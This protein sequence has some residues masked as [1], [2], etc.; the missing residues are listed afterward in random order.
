[1]CNGGYD[2]FIGLICGT[3]TNTCC[4]LPV[5]A[6]PKLGGGGGEMLVNLESGAFSGLPQ[7][8]FDAELDKA[9]AD[10]GAYRLEKMTSGAYLGELCR[11]TLRGAARDGLFSPQA[12]EFIMDL[13]YLS[14][15]D[16]D[17]LA[18]GA[19]KDLLPGAESNQIQAAEI[20]RALFDRAAR[21]A[22]MSLFAILTFTGA[23]R[24]PAS[25]VCVC[26][27]GALITQ[28][29]VFQTALKHYLGKFAASDPNLFTICRTAAN[30]TII[31]SA[32][33]A[34]INK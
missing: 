13:G 8:V 27:D 24:R 10:P 2:G 3:G 18:A 23:G 32:A 30:S 16:A 34:L 9:T 29:R 28:S 17:R 4:S 20:C 26:A 7:G 11:L 22:A 15:R 14:A 19:G 31:G 12:A 5:S 33:A 6:I 21:C 25:P 1:L